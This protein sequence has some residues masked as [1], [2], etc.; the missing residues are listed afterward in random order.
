MKQAW[1]KWSGPN[2]EI[3]PFEKRS[4]PEDH[5][6]AVAKTFVQAQE[7]R[8]DADYDVAFLWSRK[9]VETQIE[10]VADAFRSWAAVRDKP[11]AQKLLVMLLAPRQRK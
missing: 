3:V 4:V 10:S 6:R 2:I 1:V 5:L 9:E 8:E 7:R 11:E